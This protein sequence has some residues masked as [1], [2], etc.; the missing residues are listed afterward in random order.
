M[1]SESQV[2]R[3]GFS[4]IEML[5]VMGILAILIAA[6]LPML[7]GSRDSA[8]NAKCQN[9]LRNLAQAVHSWAQSRSDNLGHFPSAGLY[10]TIDIHARKKSYYAH[11]PWISNKGDVST[12]NGHTGSASDLGSVVHFTDNENDCRNAITNGAVWQGIGASFEVYRCPVHAQAFEQKFK[13]QPGWSYMMNQEFGYNAQNGKSMSFYGSSINGSIRVA[14]GTTGR[15]G[16]GEASRTPD[17]VLLFAEVQG[18]DVDYRK[19]SSSVSL[20]AVS[21]GGDGT[22]AVL[23]YTKESM[24]FNHKLGKF[25]YG[26]NVAFADG[27]VETIVYPT[28]MS[29]KDLTRYLCQGYDVPH[30]GRAYNPSTAD[31]K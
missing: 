27:H 11:R 7:G 2:S 10:R 3:K 13:H 26:G 5:V 14:T 30:D 12:L 22:D 17:K 15:R 29:S 6:L 25:K 20:Q 4:L 23:E 1:N 31:K 21:G 16:D 28:G 8:M 24:G 9:N 19:G 18:V